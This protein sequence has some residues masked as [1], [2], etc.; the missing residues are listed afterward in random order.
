MG[1]RKS[2]EGIRCPK[3]EREHGGSEREGADGKERMRLGESS[4]EAVQ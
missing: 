3:K 4:W 2:G 1:V